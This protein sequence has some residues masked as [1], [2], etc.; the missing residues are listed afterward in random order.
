MLFS[1][2]LA[3]GPNIL[4]AG[5]S[6]RAPR[7]RLMANGQEVA[8]VI[9][10]EVAANNH[11]AADR[12]A[13][14]IALG[15]LGAP[16]F[17]QAAF[18]AAEPDIAIEILFS[19]NAGASFQSLIQGVVDTV[20][21]DPVIGQ[22]RLEGR[23][24]AS[25]LIEA[26]T[27]ETFANRTASE[28][29]TLL[30]E[31]HG[32]TP[33]VSATATPVGRY[34]ENEHDRITLGQFSRATTEWDL[35]VF[36]AQQERAEIF[37]A[38]NELH[39]E[40]NQSDAQ[41]Q[42]LQQTLRPTDMIDLHLER[43]LTLA[44]DIE[45]TV[46]SWNSHNQSA[47]S[48]TARASRQKGG[49]LTGSGQGTHAGKPQRYVYVRPNLTPDAALKLAQQKLAELTR[50]ERVIEFSMP[51]ELSLTPRSRLALI[52]TATSFDQTYYVD[53]ID[54]RLNIETGFTQRIRAKNSSPRDQ[55]T[56]P[57]DTVA[58]VTG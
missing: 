14:T 22:L 23:D 36:L 1:D 53:T 58:S 43:S 27:Q 19:L 31:R 7:L 5:P 51:G 28:I 41:T 37:V 30:A 3:G 47:F 49:G 52:G 15:A 9:E 40:V 57:A 8:A 18:W 20:T 4:L 55:A 13:A 35:L 29:A 42:L 25:Q 39:F 11:Y 16:G 48:Q 2:T 12:F 6:W 56:T 32:L 45:V 26:R 21:I 33:V 38:G 17:Q 34:Y 10:A 54:R 50:H 46:K 24:L 44:R